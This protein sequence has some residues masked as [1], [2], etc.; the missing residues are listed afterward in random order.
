MRSEHHFLPQNGAGGVLGSCGDAVMTERVDPGEVY[1]ANA[2]YY[3]LITVDRVADFDPLLSDF[4]DGLGEE[5]GVLLDIGAGTGSFTVRLAELSQVCEVFAI[6]PSPSLR[7]ILASRV[8]QHPGLTERITIFPHTLADVQASL[9][10]QIGGA[11]AFGVL[12]HFSPAERLELLQMFADRL[13]PGARALIEVMQ[14]W[15]ADAIPASS[16]AE[17][18]QGRHTVEGLMQAQ[19]IGTDK[20]CWTMTYRRR[21]EQGEI[22]HEAVADNECWVVTPEAFAAEAQSLGLSVEWPRPDIAAIVASTG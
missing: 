3:D 11:I 4:V 20:L 16:F 18:R 13:T 14:P 12:P 9:P 5:G 6:E 1:A 10:K 8:S 7:S 19:P 15:I 22:I 17:V 21:N 2:E